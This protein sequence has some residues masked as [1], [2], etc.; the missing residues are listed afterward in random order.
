MPMLHRFGMGSGLKRKSR[1]VTLLAEG[2]IIPLMCMRVLSVEK[3]LI[4]LRHVTTAPT[5]GQE[6]TVTQMR[7]I[8]FRGK[9]IDNG[10]W[11]NG[12]PF[13]SQN[14][15]KMIF[16]MALHPDFV[17]DGNVYYSEGYPVDP[18]TVGQYTGLTDKNGK[19]IFEGDICKIHN[20]VYKVEF[21]YSQ[22]QFTILSKT[23]YC[24]PAFNSYC[25]EYCE[26]IGNIHDNPELLV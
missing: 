18:E 19:R 1:R 24:Y 16:A 5:A 2:T 25:G 7:E 21:K 8:L 12:T 23:V 11:V 13:I 6:W 3:C 20:L 10:E 14:C 22:W 9:R 26:V 17:E 15:C 4:F